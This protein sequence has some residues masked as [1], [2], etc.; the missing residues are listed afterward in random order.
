MLIYVYICLILTQLSMCQPTGQVANG[1]HK[2]CTKNIFFHE[3]NAVGHATFVGQPNKVS[4][5]YHTCITF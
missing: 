5:A 3:K 4:Q 2:S 1:R